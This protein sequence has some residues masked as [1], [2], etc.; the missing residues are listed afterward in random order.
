MHYKF[1]VEEIIKSGDVKIEAIN[2]LSNHETK[3]LTI[4]W[5]KTDK[6]FPKIKQ[7]IAYSKSKLSEHRI[8]LP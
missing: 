2:M 1:L 3:K 6:E 8:L 4:D 5:N 7:F